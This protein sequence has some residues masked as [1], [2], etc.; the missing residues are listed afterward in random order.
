[1]IGIRWFFDDDEFG[2][3]RFKIECRANDIYVGGASSK[4]FW[5]VQAAYLVL[6]IIFLI[7]TFIIAPNLQRIN[8]LDVI[9]K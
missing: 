6:P 7:T 2:V 8:L 1:M 4:L 3:E 5:L 9:M